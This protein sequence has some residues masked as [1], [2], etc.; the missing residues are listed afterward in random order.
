MLW[1]AD[2]SPD[3]KQIA[4]GGDDGALRIYEAS[5]FKLLKKYEML[6]AVQCL[7]WNKNGKILAIALDNKPLQLLNVETE[8]FFKVQQIC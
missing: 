1:T 5:T 4:I 6:S 2:W 3:D 7:D 8:Q